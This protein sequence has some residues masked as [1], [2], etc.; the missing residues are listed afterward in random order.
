MKKNKKFI[1]MFL[2]LIS[3]FIFIIFIRGSYSDLITNMD[4]NEKKIKIYKEKLNEISYLSKTQK[5]LEGFNGWEESQKYSEI[6]K[7]FKKADEISEDMIIQ[8]IYWFANNRINGVK[9][10]WLSMEKGVKNE[11]WFIELRLNISATVKD[12]KVMKHFFNFLIKD[13]KYK[14][15]I[16][17]FNMP[18]EPSILWYRIQ[19]PATIF[20]IENK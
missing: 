19:I 9:I 4:L 18:K 12:E 7:Y 20:Y 6:K 11:L 2:V 14:I 13:S 17:S 5:E 16:D 10:L 8:E 1:E 3:L 15:F